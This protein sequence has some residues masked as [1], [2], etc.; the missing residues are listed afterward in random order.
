MTILDEIVK[1][2]R[3]EELPKQ[4]QAREAALVRAEAKL[5]PKPKDFV[6]ALRA[7]EQI[8]LIA[9]VKKASPSKA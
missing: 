2:K 5:A 8:A 6:A 1:Y 7:T 4:M 9:E 3:V